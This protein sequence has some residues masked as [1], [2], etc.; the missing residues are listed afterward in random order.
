[1]QPHKRRF[2]ITTP[3]QGWEDAINEGQRLRGWIANSYAQI[4]YLLG[5]LILRC[6][7]FP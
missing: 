7:A 4:E 6:R 2:E 1:M 5:D 3:P